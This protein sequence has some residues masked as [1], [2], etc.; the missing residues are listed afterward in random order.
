MSGA[1]TYARWVLN[2]DN[3]RE[4]GRLIKL[5]AQRFI[6]DLKRTDVYFDEKEAVKMPNFGE[7]YCYQ[8]EGDWRDKLVQFELWQRFIYEQAY[9]WFRTDDKLRRFDEVFVE[10]AKKNGKS[11]MCAVDI[12]FH[13]IADD[14]VNTPKIFTGA[15]NEE[16][17]K[18]C[19]NMAGRIIERSPDLM[20]LV[21]DETLRLFNYKEL[22]TEIVNTEKDGFVKAFSKETGDK[23][24]KT[25]GGKHGVNASKG[26]IDEY[27]MSPDH[28]A[29][30]PIKTSMASRSE[31]QMFYIT[32][33][34]YNLDGPC[35]SELRKIGIDV[36]EGTIVR[37]NYLPV[38]FEIDSPIGEDG[39]PKPITAQWLMDNEWV[40]KHANP[41]IDVSVKRKFLRAALEEAIL[42]GG[43]TMVDTLT[44]NFNMWMDS[45]EVFIPA[46]VWNAN[47]HGIDI[48]DCG[49]R[50]F[51]GLEIAPS[52]ELSALAVL[53]PG[54]INKIEMLYFCAEDA[55]K[56][57][58]T[59]QKNKSLI[60][61]DAGNEVDNEIA[62]EW[63][64]ERFQKYS[65]HSFCFP[66]TQKNNSIVQGLIKAGY[67]G[68][69]ISQGVNG[70][71]NATE[72]WEKM[73]RAG[74]IE[75]FGNPILA[76]Q[77]SNCL[78]VRK[79]AGTRI[80]KSS[81]V[82]GIYACINA[83]AQWKAIDAGQTD[84][85]VIESW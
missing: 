29:A 7:R 47:V 55:L 10:I 3:S 24:A 77:N 23:K 84:D 40:W 83:I 73:L 27:G 70:I 54:D 22:I 21:S 71:A 62:I 78:A 56:K 58:E 48:E 42:I 44:L 52:G 79:E 30:K 59:Y 63:I 17:A 41:N 35:Y 39:K 36:L 49:G 68:N 75:H 57:N 32:T 67:E 38:I 15:N 76:W 5:A 66:V 43:G 80:E 85:A 16:Q 69:P 1:E 34:G 64:I 18:I 81:R 20:D 31:G 74:E 60:L 53:S 37:D 4:T 13:L 51:A 26:I 2:P 8:W 6:N 19:V 50:A 65:L 33:A 28:G 14:R 11:T 72:E 25:A 45:P 12:N 46:D 82:L 61:V 9:G